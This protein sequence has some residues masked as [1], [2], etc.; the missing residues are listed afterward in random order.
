MDVRVM[1][2]IEGRKLKRYTDF[3][4]TFSPIHF[5]TPACANNT[6][7][8]KRKRKR[9]GTRLLRAAERNSEDGTYEKERQGQETK[10]HH[11][12]GR[13]P[14]ISVKGFAYIPVRPWNWRACTW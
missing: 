7:F 10:I 13:Y 11:S 1:D 14:V 2:V 12:K 4:A 8:R 9:G 5:A 6:R 3:S